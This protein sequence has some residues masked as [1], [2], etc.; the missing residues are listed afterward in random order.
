MCV[1]LL[2]FCGLVFDVDRVKLAQEAPAQ[3][4]RDFGACLDF[5]EQSIRKVEEL[6]A[7]QGTVMTGE[8]RERQA[9][10]W[11]AYVGEVAR[12]KHGGEWQA[13]DGPFA[14]TVA[15]RSRAGLTC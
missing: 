7:R 12:K 9:M 6:A 13:G 3:V 8:K 15:P 2:C 10:L 4:E 1:R 14:G 5:G 11:G